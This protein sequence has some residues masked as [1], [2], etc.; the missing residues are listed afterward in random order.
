[1]LAGDYKKMC[2]SD[3]PHRTGALKETLPD[4]AGPPGYRRNIELLM[5]DIQ[6]KRTRL[7]AKPIAL[8]LQPSIRCNLE[9][10]MCWQRDET[11]AELPP[12]FY[13][14]VQELLPTLKSLLLQGGEPLLIKQCRRLIRVSLSQPW[15]EV[16]MIT[17]GTL[18]SD[19]FL[20]L[21]RGVK[22]RWMLVSLDAACAETYEII[23]GGDF[24]R[25]CEGIRRVLHHR[26]DI[27][28]IIGFVVM[29]ENVG[30]IPAFARL[31]DELNVEFEFSPLNP[32]FKKGNDFADRD[33]RNALSAAIEEA[34]AYMAQVGRRNSSLTSVKQ[35]MRNEEAISLRRKR[36]P[37]PLPPRGSIRAAKAPQR[38]LQ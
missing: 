18:L 27:E 5:Q 26:P 16:S 19:N 35:R 1:M 31:A 22:V 14:D 7:R 38:S 17:N 34:E 9:C 6:A 32:G 11:D 15:L 13:R 36:H 29:N 8:R 25:V 12:A 23:R 28:V 33:F 21:I 3:C 10:I 37:A 24:D 2:P 4:A 20:D 30:E